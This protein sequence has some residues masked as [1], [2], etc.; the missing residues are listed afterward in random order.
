MGREQR[1]SADDSADTI[2]FMEKLMFILFQELE[3]LRKSKTH[4]FCPFFPYAFFL[5]AVR[6]Q[7]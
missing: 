3:K 5:V 4:L 7:Y 2:R 1:A 6:L